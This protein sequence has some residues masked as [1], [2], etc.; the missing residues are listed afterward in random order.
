MRIQHA[1]NNSIFM[2]KTAL[3]E[4]TLQQLLFRCHFLHSELADGDINKRRHLK[5][6]ETTAQPQINNSFH[7]TDQ[8]TQDSCELLGIDAQNFRH[9]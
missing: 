5:L 2:I 8:E 1:F 9:V 6:F 4:A 3:E 7:K